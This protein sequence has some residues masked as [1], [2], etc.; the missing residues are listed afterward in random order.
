MY[1][2]Q[3]RHRAVQQDPDRVLTICGNRTRPMGGDNPAPATDALVVE[4]LA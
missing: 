4:Y 2:T 1:L 3:A